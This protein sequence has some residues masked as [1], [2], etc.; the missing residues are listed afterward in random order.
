MKIS[1]LLLFFLYFK[2]TNTPPSPP[3]FTLNYR[4]SSWFVSLCHGAHTGPEKPLGDEVFMESGPES[5]EQSELQ[6]G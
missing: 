6:V 1:L 3:L 4:P 2:H 5:A